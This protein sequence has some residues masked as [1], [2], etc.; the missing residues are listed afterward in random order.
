[1]I[2]PASPAIFLASSGGALDP[3]M[4]IVRARPEDAEALT[5]IVF[6]AKRHWGYPESWIQGWRETLTIRPESIVANVAY[7]AIEDDRPVGLYLLTEEGDGL[8]LGHLWVLPEAMGRGIGRAL[9]EHAVE[10]ARNLGSSVIKI[11][12]DPNAEEFYL[13][14]GAKRIGTNIS[15]VDGARRELPLLTY[16]LL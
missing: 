5:E 1:L 11:E 14:M 7:T 4:R 15:E 9:F 16:P 3:P 10:Q 13:H 2:F 8:D 6:A 12:S